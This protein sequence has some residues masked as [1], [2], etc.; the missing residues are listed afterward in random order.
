MTTNFW[1]FFLLANFH[2]YVEW[3]DI[4]VIDISANERQNYL[5]QLMSLELQVLWFPLRAARDREP[6]FTGTLERRFINSIDQFE[7]A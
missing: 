3:K 1:S 2:V 6:W 5:L 4:R 7:R